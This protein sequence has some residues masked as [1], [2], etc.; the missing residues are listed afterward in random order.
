M[1]RFVAVFLLVVL[2]LLAAEL[3]PWGQRFVAL[4]WTRVLAQGCAALLALVDPGVVATGNILQSSRDGFAVA[5]EAG[6]NGIEAGIVLLAA[7]A[8]FPAPWTYR[9]A[10]MAAGLVAI[11][12]LN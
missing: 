5:I 12:A 1:A 3:T 8:A 9:L 10:G 6:C 4:P 11:Q 7:M 2:G